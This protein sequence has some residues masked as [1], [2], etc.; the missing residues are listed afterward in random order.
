MSWLAAGGLRLDRCTS[1]L[2]SG[3]LSSMLSRA[4]EAAPGAAAHHLLL[5]QRQLQH[6]AAASRGDCSGADTACDA[7]AQPDPDALSCSTQRPRSRQGFEPPLNPPAAAAHP[8]LASSHLQAPQQQQEGAQRPPP[9]PVDALSGNSAPS[10]SELRAA[11]AQLRASAEAG[12]PERPR[13]ISEAFASASALATRPP[14]PGA[15][16]PRLPADLTRDLDALL[17]GSLAGMDAPQLDRVLM[18]KVRI[19]GAERGLRDAFAHSPPPQLLRLHPGDLT[20]PYA[21]GVVLEAK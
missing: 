14:A 5:L 16:P 3:P 10:L 21:L 6:D 8:H 2:L 9:Q 12:G 19:E 18:A 20:S 4:V 11:V 7:G 13:L 15:P 1:S 17:I